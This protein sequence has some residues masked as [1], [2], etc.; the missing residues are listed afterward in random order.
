MEEIDYIFEDTQYFAVYDPYTF[1]VILVG[2]STTFLDEDHIVALEEDLALQILEGIVLLSNCYIDAGSK[3]LELVERQYVVK[4]DDIL[5]RIVEKKWSADK[6]FEIYIDY[7]KKKNTLKIEMT[8]VYNGTK[9]TKHVQSKKLSWAGD[10]VMDFYI[11]DYNDPHVLYKKI[12]FPVHALEKNVVV[13]ENINLPKKFS[14]Y[15]RRIFKKYVLD[16]R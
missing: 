10:T 13:I 7:Y 14:V 16:I 11:T 15:T 2:P 6:L 9:K 12:S 4:I 8:S 1:L 5:H 3:S